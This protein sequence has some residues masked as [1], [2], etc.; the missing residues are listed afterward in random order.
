MSGLAK[1]LQGIEF[2]Q[3]ALREE[4]SD[5]KKLFTRDESLANL[6]RRN[7]ERHLYMQEYFALFIASLERKLSAD[8]QA[9]VSDMN[10]GMGEWFHDVI[11]TDDKTIT[12]YGG[13][14]KIANDPLKLVCTTKE[15]FSLNGLKPNE[16]YSV[17]QVFGANP[18]LGKNIW[19]RTYDKL[20]E[21]IKI[22]SGL[23]LPPKNIIRPVGRGCYVFNV[24]A[25][26]YDGSASRGVVV[27]KK[28]SAR[29]ENSENTEEE[30]HKIFRAVQEGKDFEYDGRSY[31]CKNK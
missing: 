8:N 4:G 24:G 9:I 5:T 19:T 12:F 6:Q 17:E 10:Q 27:G 25:Y 31:F 3:R 18:K 13:V 22:C 2:E 16:Y 21:L 1:V 29:K 28:I 23:F 30:M 20:P 14:S 7:Y 26:G 15:S 11:S